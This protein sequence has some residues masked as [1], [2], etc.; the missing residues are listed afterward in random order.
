MNVRLML[1]SLLLLSTRLKL[2]HW[3]FLELSQVSRNQCQPVQLFVGNAAALGNVNR[4]AALNILRNA[5]KI[6]FGV[7]Y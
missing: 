1:H 2:E 5:S 3:N 7:G 6:R 4:S